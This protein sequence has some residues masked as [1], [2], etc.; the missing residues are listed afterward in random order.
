[1]SRTQNADAILVAPG[2][3]PA[4]RAKPDEPKPP[5][6][7][8]A[9]VD[10]GSVKVFG[11]WSM[12]CIGAPEDHAKCQIVQK[13]VSQQ[14]GQTVLVLAVFSDP[15]TGVVSM[16]VAVPLGVLVT[17]GAQ[18]LVGEKYQNGVQISRCTQ[19]GCLIEGAASDALVNAMKQEA[20]GAVI[21]FNEAEKQIP[22]RFSLRGFTAG[23]AAMVAAN[24]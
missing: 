17:R 5:K 21:V 24:L 10:S 6:I 11:D 23:Y 7:S 14:G 19:Q 4:G 8:T 9:P 18:L 22:I 12:Q 20:T 2:E 1:M 3:T 13:V 16:Q 15:K